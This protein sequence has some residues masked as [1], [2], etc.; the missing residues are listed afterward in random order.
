MYSSSVISVLKAFQVLRSIQYDYLILTV[1]IWTVMINRMSKRPPWA[2]RKYP[3]H[4]Y[5][6]VT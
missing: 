5:V 1:C 6:A 2:S 4:F 3:S